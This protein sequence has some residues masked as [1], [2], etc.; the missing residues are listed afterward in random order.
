MLPLL[1]PLTCSFSPPALFPLENHLRSL[2]FANPYRGKEEEMERGRFRRTFRRTQPSE[3][4]GLLS[5]LAESLARAEGEQDT[6]L[7]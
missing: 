7:S 6:K 5:L 1:S 2:C 4:C 3:T